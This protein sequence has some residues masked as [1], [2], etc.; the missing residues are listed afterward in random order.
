MSA[1]KAEFMT[2]LL[3]EMKTDDNTSCGQDIDLNRPF[4]NHLSVILSVT[5][6]LL[7]LKTESKIIEVAFLLLQYSSHLC[8]GK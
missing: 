5:V 8:Y 2:G 7:V 4:Q 3:L 6:N 1:T